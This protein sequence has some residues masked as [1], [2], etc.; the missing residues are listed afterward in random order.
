MS[1]VY[2]ISYNILYYNIADKLLKVISIETYETL[3]DNTENMH[4]K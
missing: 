4:V 1:L 2:T 3:L